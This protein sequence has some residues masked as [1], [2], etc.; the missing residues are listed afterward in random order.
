MTTEPK[1]RELSAEEEAECR[2][3][4][5]KHFAGFSPSILQEHWEAG[6]GPNFRA[7]Y[8]AGL[9]A[10][11]GAPESH[12]QHDQAVQ[13]DREFEDWWRRESLGALHDDAF[14]PKKLA[15]YAW[16]AAKRHFQPAPP[17]GWL[18]M[19]NEP[20]DGTR[21]LFTNGDLI[22]TGFYINGKHFAADSW[23]GAQ[24]TYPTYWQRLPL[25]PKAD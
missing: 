22:G 18:P 3:A 17:R 11:Q 1:A 23:Q 4:F 14:H 8:A 15:L 16:N 5:D 19:G 20:K 2:L 9:S 13:S 6:H 21:F 7:A 10:R 25:P 12:P 24:N